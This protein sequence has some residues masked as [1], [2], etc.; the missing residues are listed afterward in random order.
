MASLGTKPR[1]SVGSPL[2][3]FGLMGRARLLRRGSRKDYRPVGFKLLPFNGLDVGCITAT[4]QLVWMK[5]V[6][7]SRFGIG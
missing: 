1:K 3:D 4:A 6:N 7:M 5:S 2:L